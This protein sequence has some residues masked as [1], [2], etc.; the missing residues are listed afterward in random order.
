MKDDTQKF[1]VPSNDTLQIREIFALRAEGKTH[2][3]IAGEVGVST[4][5]VSVVLGREYPEE[6]VSD[7]LAVRA[8][9]AKIRRASPTKKAKA[10]ANGLMPRAEALGKYA[11]A[12]EAGGKA[13]EAC[14]AAGITLEALTAF[15]EALTA[16]ETG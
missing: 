6:I 4:A 3:A 8:H 12:L 16:S 11:E 9:S 7:D 5:Q 2:T 10:K 14:T 1:E 15:R 13:L